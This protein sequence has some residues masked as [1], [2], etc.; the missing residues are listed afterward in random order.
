[1]KLQEVLKTLIAGFKERDI[2][3]ELVKE[4]FEIFNKGDLL[5]EWLENIK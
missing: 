2:D 4:Y 5:D 1:M 3:L